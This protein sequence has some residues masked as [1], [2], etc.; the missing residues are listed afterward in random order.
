M[1]YI[2]YYLIIYKNMDKYTTTYKN[3]YWSRIINSIKSI[4]IWILLIIISIFLLW[5]N[6]WRTINTTKW[7]KEWEKITVSWQHTP[8]DNSLEWKLIHISWKAESKW[9]I[10]D[11]VFFIEE[12][13]IKIYR[14]VEMYQWNEKET[15]ESKDNLWWSETVTVTQTYNKIWSKTKIN[16]NTFKN[17]WYVNPNN[18]LYENKTIVSDSVYIWDL[19][20]WD[21]FIDKMNKKDS[22]LISELNIKEFIN[23]NS[24]HD[25]KKEWNYIYIWKWNISSPEIWDLRIS[26]SLVNSDVVTVVWKQ[27]WKYIGSYN[28]KNNISLNLLQ[29]WDLSIEEIYK[30]EYSNNKLFAWFLR[31]VW[32]M[33]MFIWFK[34]IMWPIVILGKVVPFISKILWFWTWLIAF[35]LTLILWFWIIIIA[36]LF[37]RPLLSI[38]LLIIVFWTIFWIYKLKEKLIIKNKNTE[39]QES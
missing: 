33:T 36:W 14:E 15:K 30:I 7:L 10:K 13:A 35:V 2:F 5:W 23:Q 18:W 1:I 37:V 17:T 19:K 9:T 8:I 34:L 21:S 12:E 24:L 3:S 6:E 32:L 31:I 16:S 27:S 38:F 29:Y 22:Y 20:L 11:D 28:T 25:V 39:N 26:F 4:F